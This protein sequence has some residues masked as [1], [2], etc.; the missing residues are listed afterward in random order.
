[1]QTFLHE[2]NYNLAARHLD[3]RRLVKQI[4]ECK[5]ILTAIRGTTSWSH[6]PIVRMWTGWESN[7]VHYALCMCCEYEDRYAH[8]HSLEPWF[9]MQDCDTKK[10]PWLIEP[11]IESHQ[12]ALVYKQPTHYKLIYPLVYPTIDYLWWAPGLGFYRGQLSQPETIRL[13]GKLI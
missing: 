2:I 6:H 1:M 13:Y 7:L 5:Q 8:E 12:S 11:L 4:V 3:S 9:H 10:P